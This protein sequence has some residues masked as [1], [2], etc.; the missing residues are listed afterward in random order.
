MRKRSACFV[1]SDGTENHVISE[2][3]S[4][5]DAHFVGKLNQ[6]SAT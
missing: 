2:R 5:K 3:Y 4:V 6:K 1:S